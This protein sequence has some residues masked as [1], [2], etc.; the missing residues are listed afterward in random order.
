M[1]LFLDTSIQISRKGSDDSE[2]QKI[3]DVIKKNDFIATSSYV[4]LEFKQSYIQD[5]A[6]LHRNLVMDKSYARVLLTVKALTAHPGNVRKASMI[7]E[8]LGGYFSKTKS[9][10]SDSNFDEDLAEQVALYLEIILEN[11]WEWFNQESVDYVSDASGCIRSKEPPKRKTLAFDVTVGRCKS[12]KIR[13][14]LNKFFKEKEALF[15]T[16]RDYINSLDDTKKHKPDELKKIA[17]IIDQ[18]LVDADS[19]CNSSECRGLGDALVA[20][21]GLHFKELFTKDKD[22][23]QVISKAINLRASLLL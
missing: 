21:E 11:I 1:T 15:Q 8:I 18:G 22:Q 14:S 12:Q 16:I 2:I 7:L 13:C 5:L 17:A 10:H 20:V 4:R 23:A 6:Y 9:F 3:E 19:L